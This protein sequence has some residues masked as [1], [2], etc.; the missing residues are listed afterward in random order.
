MNRTQIYLDE[1]QTARLD[2][3][4]AA[5]GTSRSTVIRRAVDA[6]LSQ[7][8]RDAAAWQ[9]QWRQA[10]EQSAGVASHLDDGRNY[11]EDV[12]RGDAERLARLDS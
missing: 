5:E 10:L 4:A 3:R 1:A 2:E 11:V 8:E 6:Y 7:E 9:E 12:R